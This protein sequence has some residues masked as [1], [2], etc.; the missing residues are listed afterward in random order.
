MKILIAHNYYLQSGGE[1]IVFDAEASL[2][3]AHGHQVSK[4][5]MDNS[6]IR[7]ISSIEVGIRTIWNSKGY[8]FIRKN[9]E[10][11]QPDIIHFHNT[12][13]LISPAGYEAAFDCNI[14][15]VQTLHN[16]RLLC[17][18]ATLMRNGKVCELCVEKT[19]PLPGIKYKCYHDG[20]LPSAA[21]ASMLT[22]H[23]LRKTFEK[24]VNSYIVLS[25]F[26]KELFVK[27]GLPQEKIYIKPNFVSELPVQSNSEINE[28]YL[29]F[30]GRLSEEKGILSLLEAAKLSN[31]P[32]KIAGTGPLEEDITRFI[33]KNGLEYCEFIGKVPRDEVFPLMRNAL[34]VVIPS[35]WFEGFPM[36][37]AEAFSQGTAMIASNLGVMQE[38]MN[39]SDCGLGFPPGNAAELAK[40]LMLAWNNPEQMIVKGENAKRMFED[41]FSA[42]TNYANLMHIYH[43]TINNA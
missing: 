20:F 31:V 40:Q 32:L 5:Y 1:D 19:P 37:I 27:A 13:P 2:L 34:A 18:N 23:R 15:V 12:F 35:L 36:V 38:L 33:Q 9:I 8:Q 30:V 10:G 26:A 41:K 17:L 7:D 42:E 16:Y 28:K 3:E 29:L 24:R 14:P 25:G 22:I 21:I 11:F 4:I 39:E 6:I 43:E